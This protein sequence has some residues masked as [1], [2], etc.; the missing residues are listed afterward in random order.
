MTRARVLKKWFDLQWLCA[1]TPVLIF[2]FSCTKSPEQKEEAANQ[3]ATGTLFEEVLPAISGIA[4]QN[5]V[6][7]R[8]SENVLNY[9]YYFN[10]GGVALGDLNND[11]LVDVFFTGN[12]VPNKLYLN[13]G[14]FKFED[15]SDRAGVTNF[16]GWRTGVT[17]ADFNHD[18]FLDIYVCRSAANDSTLR[19]NLLFVNNGDLTFTE[20]AA[21]FA[22]DDTSYS[23]QAAFFDYDKD[24][25]LDLFVL[26]H[27]LPQYAGFNNMLVNNKK[28]KAAAFHSKLYR[29]DGGKFHDVSEKAGLTNNVLSFGLGIAIADVNSDGW[30][31][32]YVSNDFN[33]EDYFYVNNGNGTFRESVRDAMGHVSLFSMGSDIADINNDA[34]PDI[35]TA[36]ML[37]ESNERI[38]L[39]SGDDNYDKY[40][41]LVHAGFHH[42]TMR[43]MLQ[44]NNGDGTFSEIGQLAGVSSTDWSWAPLFADFDNDGW[45]DLYVTNGYEKDYTNMQFLKYT[46]DEQLKSRQTGKPLDLQQIIN[47]MPAI[48]VGNVVFHNQGN[49]TFTNANSEWGLSRTFKS[50]GA[51]TADLDNDGDLDLVI[52]TINGAASIYRNT[53][54]LNKKHFLA[55]DLFKKNAGKVIIGTRAYLYA[56]G[57]QQYLE[58]SPARG[59]QSAMYVPLHFGLGDSK[60]VDSL[61]LIW[62]NG[63]SRL[64]TNVPVDTT[65]YPVVDD[66]ADPGSRRGSAVTK[67]LYR[68]SAVMNWKQVPATMNDFKRQLLLPRM[69]SYSGPRMA[70]ADVNADGREDLYVCGPKGQA[71]AIMIQQA[72]GK[73]IEMKSPGISADKDYQDEDAAFLDA[74]KDGDL[75]LYVVSGGYMHEG[76]HEL[77][78]DRLYL[79]DGHGNFKRLTT[80]LP[81]ESLAGGCVATLDVN[82]DG[83]PDIFVGTRLTPGSYP[84]AS[85]SLLLINDG[86]G[87]FRNATDEEAPFLNSLGMVC[88]A[89]AADV[90]K[91][92]EQDL[93][94]AGEWS[95]PRVFIKSE[96]RLKDATSTL[97]PSNLEGWWNTLTA[98]DFDG[99]GDI[100]LIAGNAGINNLYNASSETPVTLVYKDFN[101]D[102]QIDPFLNYF[103]GGKSWPYASRDEALGQVGALRQRFPDYTGYSN[104]TLSEIFSP[105]QL[106]G[107]NELRATELRTT[108][109]ENTGTKFEIRTLPVEAQFAPVYATA[110]LDADGDGDLDLILAGNESNTRVRIGKS[111][112]NY[113]M[114]FLN[115][116][117]GNFTYVH[118]N[119]SGLQVQGDVR[120]IVTPVVAGKQQVIFG[121][122]G[123][124]IAGYVRN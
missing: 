117:K 41:I 65:L 116:G 81:K 72:T 66:A 112:A 85:P 71:G 62:P 91:D 97:I 102:G 31:D 37:P 35:F 99:D 123:S 1:A 59:F 40:S 10:G 94:V 105:E 30:S 47:Q 25:D 56:N 32:I 26:N 110:A 70:S 34:L 49:L 57:Q 90:N 80:A 21:E 103:I 18:G 101:S 28:K 17:M 86:K 69:Y 36:D 104:V 39:S 15:I 115:D 23:T 67:P 120:D 118:Q 68:E 114:L 38:K 53:G 83:A 96:G 92:G 20:R 111:D 46:V 113:G 52:N 84:V 124:K 43:N 74:D 29:N 6:V 54:E 8:G 119:V 77:L 73:F 3:P 22:I 79:N 63:K 44:L 89:L 93:V 106:Q 27:S 55:V 58:F 2:A 33:E 12:Q 87:A 121:V 61:R 16:Q 7:Q 64:Y 98:A 108:Y 109:L 11:G 42:Q 78:Q 24:N 45:K 100:D 19:R 9:P 122:T 51:A 14:D 107:A 76:P 5:T 75:D 50:N 13:K 95:T 60:Q 4:F 48:Q 88:D 82:N